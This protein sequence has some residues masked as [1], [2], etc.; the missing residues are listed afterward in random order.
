MVERGVDYWPRVWAA[1]GLLHVQP[2]VARSEVVPVLMTSL[3]DS[4]WR[5]REMSAKVARRWQVAEA[6]DELAALVGDAT[7]RVR[8][9]AAGA[10][11]VVGEFEQADALRSALD[12]DDP[13]VRRAADGAL[14]ELERRLDRS[15]RED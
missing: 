8:A 10:L 15:V 5:V 11:G 4:A 6:A 14:D 2:Q 12:D 1:R 3:H 7:P 13:A 9:A